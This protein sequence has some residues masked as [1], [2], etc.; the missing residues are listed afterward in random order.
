MQNGNQGLG[1]LLGHSVI[2]RKSIVHGA[3]KLI[4]AI[5][6]LYSVLLALGQVPDSQVEGTVECGVT[7]AE[8]ERIRASMLGRNESCS[9]GNVTLGSILGV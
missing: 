2:D 4:G 3:A 8:A 9:Y 7:A 1:F 5:T 6:T